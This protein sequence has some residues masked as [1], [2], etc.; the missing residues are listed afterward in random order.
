MEIE[1]KKTG[2]VCPGKEKRKLG[3]DEV[4]DKL[5][6]ARGP[7]YWRTLDEL[8]QTPE[9]EEMLQREFPRAAMQFASSTTR[10]DVLKIMGASLALG[11]LSACVKLPLQPIVPYVRQPEEMVL[12]KPLFFASTM[13]L[14]GQPVPVLVESHEGRPTKIEG[15]PQ[16]PATLGGSDV[17]SQ[18]SVLGMYDPDRSQY[19]LY[20]GEMRSWGQ[21]MDALRKPIADQKAKGGAG[22]RFLSGSTTSPTL[23]A[24]MK[25]VQKAFP[26]SKW[27]QWDPVN[28]DNVYEG[29]KLAFGQPVQTHYNFEK[30]KVILSLDGEFLSSTFPGFHQY[31][32][33][34]AKRRRPEL[35]DEMVRFYAAESTPTNTGAKAD[36]RL[37]VKASEIEN[38]ARAV[39]SQLGIA[40]A[41]GSLK[42]S[43]SQQFVAA[44]VKD[45]QAN[46]G[47]A[48]VIA[49][50]SQ[51]PA[52]HALAHA[53]NA[54][55]GAAG[56][57][58]T[59]SDP[60]ESGAGLN[61]AEQL[62][63]LVD[64]MNGGK[65]EMLVI[66]SANPL[67][68]QPQDIDFHAALDKVGM[69]IHHGLYQDETAQYCH[70]HVNATHYLEQW[71][72]ARTFEGT[73]S[74]IQPLIAPLYSG[75]SEHEMIAAFLGQEEAAGFDIVQAYWKSQHSGADFNTWWRTAL[76][77][78]FVANSANPQRTMSAKIAA[79]P[80]TAAPQGEMEI[81]LRP[82]PSVFDGRF[83]NNAWLQ[84]TPKPFTQVCWDNAVLMGVETAKKLKIETEDE[85]EIGVGSQKLKGAVWVTPGHPDDAITVFVG[86]GREKAGRV[87][88]GLG[89]N[90]YKL[91]SGAA[92]NIVAGTVKKTGG[93]YPLASPQGDQNM[94][95][96]ALVRVATLEEFTKNPA[97]AH[98]MVEAPA[99]G[100]TMYE[101]YQ[102]KEHKW[103][104][105]IDLNSCIGCNTCTVACYAENNI[106][107]VGKTEVK[108]GHIMHWLR[109]DTY[110]E[111]DPH[112]PKTYFQP[113]PC[114]Q[115]ENAPCEVVCPVGATTHSTEGLNDMVYNRCV[116]TRYCSNNCPYKV[117]RFNFLLYSDW[118][119]QQ[120]KFQR[121]PD[122][123]VRSRGVMEKCTFCVQRL[124]HARIT[125]E[126]QNRKVA[127][128]EVLTA[129]QQACP[130]DAIVFGDMNDK[131]SRV[132]K[133][134]ASERNYG[135]LEDLNTRPRT[136]YLA[137]VRNPN[138]ELEAQLEK[139][140]ES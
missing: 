115:C 9:F 103:G 124:T 3:L 70:W 128:G 65:V 63:S 62:K 7:R 126:E 93:S 133:L 40:G 43:R 117:R 112:D 138:M 38:V 54:Q 73:T 1:N 61:K 20:R 33:Q 42:D 27:Y 58:V 80:Q 107:V 89:F 51:S 47:R 13:P 34:F 87:G 94:H 67:Y 64:E 72:D 50:D 24:Q 105:A 97:F 135:L 28:R 30:A 136:T 45:L 76:H 84:E 130:A 92:Q 6:E 96:R 98:E 90:G 102:Y 83:A 39:A 88:S 59:F 35:K 22:L 120:T 23:I 26:Q 44:V 14:N 82:D 79:P 104:M 119:T 52:V 110:H 132:S 116:G 21:M 32:L 85:I 106:S 57:T 81:I 118:D 15:N 4:K 46:R 41:G 75:R 37:R 69:R 18:A 49:G 31:A 36:H 113:L 8:A 48:V 122:V 134:K 66:L 123:T 121:N 10:R 78:G 16:H 56:Q 111:G 86:Y 19:V 68:D 5:T 77:D 17:Y 53:I 95:G 114:M 2:D 137:A 140:Q 108:R 91:R 60:V 99:P 12:G 139:G 125:A 100:L 129:C 29:A 55:I 71:G 127:D 101:A 109:I 25:D 131:N 11:G 74:I